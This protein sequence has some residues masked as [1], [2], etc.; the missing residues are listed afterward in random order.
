MSYVELNIT[1]DPGASALPKSGIFSAVP[2]REKI[3]LNGAGLAQTRP[4]A[5]F[6]G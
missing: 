5:A 1:H 3:F 6:W 2:G 4:S